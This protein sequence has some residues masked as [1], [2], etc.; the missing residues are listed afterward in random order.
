MTEILH[1]VE[2]GIA[3]VTLNRPAVRNAV[4][5]AM[6]TRLA[7]LFG[8]FGGDPAIRAVI[9]TGAGDDFSA[10]ADIGE[11]GT[12]RDDEAQTRAYDDAVAAAYGTIGRL[13]KP[14]IAAT[15]GYCLGGGAL[16]AMACDFR[17]AH[18]GA[19]FGIPAA[20]L[21]IVY[22]VDGT[23]RL[24]A[25]V[26]LS[27]AKHILYSGERFAAAEALDIGFVDSVEDDPLAAARAYALALA[28][29]APLTIAG[30][31]YILDSAAAGGFDALEA[32]RLVATASRSDDYREGRLAFA[33]KRRPVFRGS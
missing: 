13:A 11:F 26:G 7:A 1:A 16:L 15:R 25:L 20:R 30:A 5:F 29:S 9:L 27:R 10:G 24:A 33:E 6:W 14:V 32:Q 19:T 18:H 22:D 21:S 2:G 4:T 28:D 31:K 12:N 23:R 8:E 3:T 17:F